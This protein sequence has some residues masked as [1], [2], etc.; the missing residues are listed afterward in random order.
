MCI[1]LFISALLRFSALNDGLRFSAL[2]DGFRFSALN[3]GLR[4]SALN[5]GFRFSAMNDGFRFSALNDGLRFSALNDGLRSSALNDGLRFS[6]WIFEVYIHFV[7]LWFA[8][9]FRVD[10][11]FFFNEDYICASYHLFGFKV[12]QLLNLCCF[13]VSD[14]HTSF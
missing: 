2:N 8:D 5:D 1:F 4:F 13:G 11:V 7:C 3:D 9:S 14:H 6:G 12:A 10:I